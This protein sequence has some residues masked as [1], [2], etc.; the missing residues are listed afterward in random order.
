MDKKTKDAVIIVG[1][2]AGDIDWITFKRD[3]TA[4]ARQDYFLPCGMTPEKMIGRVKM[5]IPGIKVLD[6]GDAWRKLPRDSFFWVRF[7]VVD[8]EAMIANAVEIVKDWGGSWKEVLA[9]I[10][11]GHDSIR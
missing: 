4:E 2:G 11:A 1:M 5:T 3:G 7:K 10:K 9:E 6:A 8:C